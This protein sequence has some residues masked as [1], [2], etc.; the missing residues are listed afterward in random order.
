T[1]PPR[2]WG[3]EGVP[4]SGQKEKRHDS[5]ALSNRARARAGACAL[6]AGVAGAVG[7]ARRPAR[8]VAHFD[9]AQ[10]RG[11]GV[12]ARAESAGALSIGARFRSRSARLLRNGRSAR[13][14]RAA[15]RRSR[16]AL[17]PR[18]RDARSSH[19]AEAMNAKNAGAGATP[20]RFPAALRRS[21]RIREP[22]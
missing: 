14:G 20:R 17:S 12:L 5:Q 7:G 19:R 9:S 15:S 10:R 22:D 1:P 6:F 21:P 2:A 16:R 8:T 11:G 4:L 13:L 3:R 18:H